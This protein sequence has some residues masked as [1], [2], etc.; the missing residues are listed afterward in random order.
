MKLYPRALRF[1]SQIFV[2]LFFIGSLFYSLPSFAQE[3][4]G[5]GTG[6]TSLPDAPQPKPQETPL[7]TTTRFVGYVTNPSI[8]FPDIAT[9]EGPL[10]NGEKF[11]LFVNE[12][13]SPPYIL[14]SAIGAAFNQARNVPGAYGS[15]WNGYGGR[16]GESLARASSNSFFSTFVLASALHQDLRFFPQNRPSLWGT[17]K[18][19]AQRVFVTRTD[20]G[21]DTFNTSG[22]VGT[23]AAEALANSYLPASEQTAGKNIER[24]GTDLAW[25]FAGNVFKNYWPTL[26][27]NMGLNRL[28][29]LPDPS[30]PPET[31]G[32]PPKS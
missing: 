3:P 32:A 5:A 4:A 21:M 24:V 9:R 6:T 27:H 8:V 11:R 13:M 28:K 16:F 15:G 10:S 26:F 22:V 31:S 7:E 17:V 2:Y 18:Y 29:V 23:M 19:S 30:A 14:A 20:S 12:S 25:K 1:I